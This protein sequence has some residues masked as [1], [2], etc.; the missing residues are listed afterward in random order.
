MPTLTPLPSGTGTNTA[1]QAIKVVTPNGDTAMND[2]AD[3][4]RC[5]LYDTSGTAVSL[6]DTSVLPKGGSGQTLKYFSSALSPATG[7]T[8]NLIYTVTAG[9]VFYCTYIF[10]TDNAALDAEMQVLDDTTVVFQYQTSPGSTH[11]GS[12]MFISHVPISF[13]TTVRVKVSANANLRINIV[14]WE[15]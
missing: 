8:S 2:T 11:A 7:G 6:G 3:S 15:Q 13:A 5:T 14:G 9:K 12:P 1:T 4:V 10:I